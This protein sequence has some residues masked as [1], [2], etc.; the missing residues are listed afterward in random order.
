MSI[1]SGATSKTFDI[2]AFRKKINATNATLNLEFKHIKRSVSAVSC[3]KRRTKTVSVS[4]YQTVNP[5]DN[6]GWDAPSFLEQRTIMVPNKYRFLFFHEDCRPAYHGTWSK[7][8]SIVTGKNPFGKDC[9]VFDYEYDSEAEWEE[10]DDEMGEDV[11]DESKNEEEE[12]AEDAKVYDFED[13]FCVAD[14]MLLDNEEDTD[15][16]AKALYKKKILNRE[17]EQHNHTNRI[18]IIAPCFGG[19]PLNAFDYEPIDANLIEGI[20]SKNVSKHLSLYQALTISHEKLSLDA[21]PRLRKKEDVNIE[22]NVGGSGNKV[23]EDYSAEDMIKMIRFV[24]HSTLNSKE[25]LIEKLR[26]KHPVEFS[27]RTKATRKL[28]AIAVKKKHKK[29]TGNCVYWEVKPEILTEL[30]LVDVI[31]MKLDDIAY[32]D[33]TLASV[34]EKESNSIKGANKRKR[35]SASKKLAADEATSNKKM[36]GGNIPGPTASPIE[37]NS[38]PQKTASDVSARMKNIMANFF[39]KTSEPKQSPSA[40]VNNPMSLAFNKVRMS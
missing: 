25:K 21:F 15:E 9:S 1:K 27:T 4:V 12:D 26:S 23:K 13:G 32:D 37:K 2:D 14:E 40:D 3:R 39:K 5:D 16:D 22:L 18:S 11:E 35:K 34:G 8:S 29:Y 33:A 36:K 10:G 20:D 28:D 19:V 24:H 6:Y 7:T 31:E 30:N 17:R 38:P